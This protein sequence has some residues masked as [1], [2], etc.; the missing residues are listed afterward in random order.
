MRTMAIF[1]GANVGGGLLA[2]VTARLALR[3][4]AIADALAAQIGG[5]G[6]G[7]AVIDLL[8]V[9]TDAQVG[10]VLQ[11][12]THMAHGVRTLNYPRQFPPDFEVF[13]RQVRFAKLRG[14][15]GVLSARGDLGGAGPFKGGV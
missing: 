4:V 2:D 8:A 14:G 15:T 13:R 10:L 3:G 9:I 11:D 7:R 6:G 5:G 12:A 1:D